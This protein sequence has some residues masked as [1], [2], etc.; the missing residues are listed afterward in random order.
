[1]A[2]Y[3]SVNGVQALTAH[4]NYNE[5]NAPTAEDVE[6]WLTARSGTLN[7]WL[8]LAGFV[9]PVVLHEAK[10]VLDRY[11]NYGAAADAEAS[12]R[13]AGYREDD[14]DRREVYFAREFRR[15]E[16]W[17][18]SGALAALGVPQTLV[19]AGVQPRGARVGQLAAG[20]PVDPRNRRGRGGLR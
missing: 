13:T 18:A 3:G 6:G 7:S 2:A 11:A 5:A 14:E 9:T 10:A 12:Q 20:G 16:E 1:M 17:I 8:A 4:I 15:A 19:E